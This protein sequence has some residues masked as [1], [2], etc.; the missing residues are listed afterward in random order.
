MLRTLCL[1][2]MMDDQANGRSTA[3]YVVAKTRDDPWAPIEIR[4]RARNSAWLENRGPEAN[5]AV[6]EREL[7]PEARIVSG[8]DI[9]LDCAIEQ[10]IAAQLCERGVLRVERD[11][12]GIKARAYGGHGARLDG[13]GAVARS[14]TSEGK[15]CLR[16]TTAASALLMMIGEEPWR[17]WIGLG[18]EPMLQRGD[19]KETSLRR[20]ATMRLERTGA[21]GE[22]GKAAWD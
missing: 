15:E 17:W 19:G 13:T 20:E 5:A 2:S 16:A 10:A 4:I 1:R 21:L 8:F 7:S 9:E 12:N 22:K 14:R 11:G 18:R 6:Y 3:Q